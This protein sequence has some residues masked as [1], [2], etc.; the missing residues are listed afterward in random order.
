M[1]TL[2]VGLYFTSITIQSLFVRPHRD[3]NYLNIFVIV[4][5]LPCLH[6]PEFLESALPKFLKATGYLP[7]EGQAKLCRYWSKY[8]PKRLQSILETMQQLITVRIITGSFACKLWL[9]V[10]ADRW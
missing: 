8:E 6:S 1:C 7:L 4:F 9:M 3:K 10:K 2:Y 5:E